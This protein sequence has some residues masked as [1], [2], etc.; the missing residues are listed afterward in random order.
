MQLVTSI[1]GSKAPGDG[2]ALSIAFSR[3]SSDTLAQHLH[4]F[5]AT[6]K[7]DTRKNADL[8]LGHVQPTAVFGRIME[9]DALQDA[10]RFWRREGF[11]QGRSGVRVQI[12]LHD[13]HVV[14]L[15]IDLIHQPANAVGVV[16]LGA[17]LRHLNMTPAGKR[18]EAEKQIARAQPFL[19][20]IYPLVLSRRSGL[21]R[22]DM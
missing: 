3:Q 20:L 14:S 9:L 7:T 6:R 12:I 18:L 5:H 15:W 1:A 21:G 16:N 17:M 11:I 19:F 8:D 2:A 22:A 13:A 10:P 4:T